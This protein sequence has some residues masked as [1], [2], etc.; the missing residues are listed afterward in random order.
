MCEMVSYMVS[1]KKIVT[2]A[3]LVRLVLYSILDY[4]Y[5][6]PKTSVFV[7]VSEAIRIRIRNRTKI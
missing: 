2:N 3:I 7:F 1:Y 6:H 4:P 5:L